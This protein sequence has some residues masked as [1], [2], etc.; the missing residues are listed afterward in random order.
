MDINLNVF[1][2]IKFV[3]TLD[4]NGIL[5][6]LTCLFEGTTNEDLLLEMLKAI[7]DNLC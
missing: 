3:S 6:I 2:D 1:S 7:S 5:M 4:V